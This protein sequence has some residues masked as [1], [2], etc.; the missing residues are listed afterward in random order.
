MNSTSG[1]SRRLCR[2]CTS[3]YAVYNAYG[4]LNTATT[5]PCNSN[6]SS[7]TGH[8]YNKYLT[9]DIDM[10]IIYGIITSTKFYRMDKIMPKRKADAKTNTLRQRGCL[11]P[12]S[13]TVSDELFHHNMFFDR[14]DLVQVRYEML[15]KVKKE[16]VAVQQAVADFGVSRSTWYQAW[17]AFLK[18]GLPA[19]VP[20]RPG[21]RQAHKLKPNIVEAIQKEQGKKPE[22][23]IQDLVDFVHDNFGVKV[24]RR[25]VERALKRSKKNSGA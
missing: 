5:G 16:G 15:R 21:P 17:H 4:Q 25:S 3:N 18:G 11:N 2:I 8:I 19:L 7:Y 22:L 6:I 13:D 23:R 14:R 12:K 20:N 24:H 10:F 9:R 1:L